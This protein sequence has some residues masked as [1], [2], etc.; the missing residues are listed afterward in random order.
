M[1][2][3]DIC[4]HTTASTQRQYIMAGET[5]PAA[6]ELGGEAEDPDTG[7][8]AGPSAGDTV[9][10]SFIPLKQ[11]SNMPLMYHCFPAAVRGTTSNPLVNVMSVSLEYVQRS[12]SLAFTSITLCTCRVYMKAAINTKIL[13]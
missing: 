3:H 8:G 13:E 1:V 2:V 7:D 10:A 6:E 12:N 11:S 5:S 4:N 9:R